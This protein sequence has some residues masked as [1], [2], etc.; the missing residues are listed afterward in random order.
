MVWSS[1]NGSSAVST[2][3]SSTDS[4]HLHSPTGSCALAT[5]SWKALSLRP[6]HPLRPLLRHLMCQLLPWTHLRPC[7]HQWHR[8]QHPPPP[9]PPPPPPHQQQCQPCHPARPLPQCPLPTHPSAA[10]HSRALARLIASRP[11]PASVPAAPLHPLLLV[12]VTRPPP[13]TSQRPMPW[14]STCR[15]SALLART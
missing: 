8:C 6:P 10:V 14:G 5:V 4:V 9:Q 13:A 11:L 2:T 12:T 1:S 3:Q 7:R 15:G